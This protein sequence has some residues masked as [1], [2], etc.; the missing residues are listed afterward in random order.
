MISVNNLNSGYENKEIIR[1]LSVNIKEGEIVSIIGPNGSGKSTLLKSLGKFLRKNSGEVFID[2]KNVDIMKISDIAKIMSTLSQHNSSPDDIKVR[3]LVYYGRI[4]H[5]RWYEMKNEEDEEIV[6]WALKN[7]CTDIYSER[8]IL[9]LSGGERQRVYLAMALAQKPKVLLLDEPT[10]HL[11]M[12]HQLELMDLVV[13]IN[14]RFNMTILIVLHD[15]NQ[16]VRYSHRVIIM[17]KG[18]IVADGKSED[19]INEEIINNVYN[20]RCVINKEPVSNK[21]HIYPLEV[22]Y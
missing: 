4:P 3:D 12:C 6:N 21:L 19:I 15:L 9:E 1:N 11:D 13:D 20:V 2:K 10:T 18:D 17:K 14:N 7:T 16:A 8:R 5:K 22:S